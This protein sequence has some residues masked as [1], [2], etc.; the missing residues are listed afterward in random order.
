MLAVIKR[1]LSSMASLS[2]PWAPGQWNVS[3]FGAGV[4]LPVQVDEF[5]SLTISAVYRAVALI[6]GDIA[7]LPWHLHE[8]AGDARVQLPDHPVA[9]LLNRQPNPEMK[10]VDFKQAIQ[11]HALTWGNGYAE[12][13]RARDGT[14]IALWPLLPNMTRPVRLDSGELAYEVRSMGGEATLIRRENMFHVHGPS[15][16]GIVGYSPIRL[17]ALSLSMAKA[18]EQ[19]GASFFS[20][21]AR[22]SGALKH[23]G[24]VGDDTMA[25][26]RSSWKETYGGV[27]N[28]GRTVIL[29]Q[30]FEYQQIGLPPDEAQ[31]IESRK[32]SVIE[33]ARW[34]GVPP[35]K[36]GDIEKTTVGNIEEQN[37]S[38]K[39]DT[40]DPWVTQWQQEADTKL[41]TGG[42]VHAR[43]NLNSRMRADTKSRGEFYKMLNGMG[44]LSVNE[45]RAKEDMDPIG[46]EG[47]VR[48]VPLNMGRLGEERPESEPQAPTRSA[49]PNALASLRSVMADAV[50]TI[51]G[52]CSKATIRAQ[53]KHDEAGLKAWAKD[54]Y[55]ER[56]A[57]CSRV[58][59]PGVH[60][61]AA[62]SGVASND[63]GIGLAVS[64]W[65]GWACEMM[66]DEAVKGDGFAVDES[67]MV[68]R[69]AELAGAAV[70]IAAEKEPD[71]VGITDLVD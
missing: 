21:A 44:V 45:I 11:G 31:F 7:M 33:V 8:K 66:H 68:D 28:A 54:F 51:V 13:E 62:L 22:P 38:Y 5:Q 35:H 43:M 30:G 29:D 26:I 64:R 2:R 50:A 48:Y 34:F 39:I 69:L 63:A 53:G 65:A 18:S 55:G 37:T 20:A 36:I 24:K 16:D 19:F 56:F 15:F 25:R 12:I 6:S 1:G 4:T 71:N 10:A 40:L 58:V 46:P 49:P 70:A 41:L 57:E 3:W 9:D 67:A 59:A 27:S 32:F 61:L 60:T 42:R 52:K 17:A 23:P 14:P 47:D